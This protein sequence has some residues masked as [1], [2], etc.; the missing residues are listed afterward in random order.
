MFPKIKLSYLTTRS[1]KF[2]WQRQTRGWDDSITWN[3]DYEI[4]KWILP[5]LKR[6][7]ELNRCCPPEFTTEE[8]NEK[9]DTMVAAF[10]YI[11]S[12][13]YWSAIRPDFIPDIV[14]EGRSNFHKYFYDLWW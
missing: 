11:Q 10:E 13:E 4:A 7:K 2:W 3:L 14:E 5:K 12:D 6:F 1:I 9:I 8:W